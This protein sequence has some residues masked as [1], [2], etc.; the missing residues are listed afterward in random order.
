MPFFPDLKQF[1]TANLRLRVISTLIMAPVA[2]LAVWRGGFAFA[3]LATA[4]GVVGLYEWLNLVDADLAK[5]PARAQIAGIACAM[6]AVVMIVGMFFSLSSAM[7]AGVVFSL[8]L[9]AMARREYGGASSQPSAAWLAFGIPYMGGGG[10]ALLYLRA[11]PDIGAALVFYVLAVVWGTDV[12]AFA[13]GRLIGGPK[14]APTLSPSKTWAGLCGGIAL[15]TILGYVV[16]VC[17]GAR[18]P[19]WTV[20]LSPLLAVVAQ[21]GDLFESAFKRRSGVKES[22]DLIPGHGGVLDRIDGLVFAA[23]IAACAFGAGVD[24]F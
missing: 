7:V 20:V 13:A 5:R 19:G 24:F 3:A 16:A 1:D 10:L 15:A 22:G 12:G 4:V 8:A 17:L 18:Q 14:L 11:M 6:L 23:I 21:T 2:L 9:F